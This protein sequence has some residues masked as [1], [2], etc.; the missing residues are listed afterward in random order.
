MKTNTG[1]GFFRANNKY[2]EFSNWWLCNFEYE[3]I[4]FTSSEQAFMWKKAK[5]FG[6][7]E[8]AKQIMSTNNQHD[9][10]ALG[11]KV[12]NYDEAKWRNS[13]YNIMVDILKA[14]FT[15][16]GSLKKLLL[17]TGD[18]KLYEASPYDRVWGIGSEDINYING[19][20]LLGK[21][22]VEVREYIRSSE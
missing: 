18:Q 9:I 11:R 15:Q 14:K 2:G 3:G 7:E 13:R 22:L 16:D 4:S 1:I 12:R 17:S 8:V 19:S 20:N 21:A 10:K 5:L 6:D